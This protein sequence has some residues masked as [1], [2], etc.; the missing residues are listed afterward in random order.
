MLF[1][2]Q[3]LED[4]TVPDGEHVAPGAQLLKIWRMRNNGA[5]DW[6]AGVQLVHRSGDRFGTPADGVAATIQ[7]SVPRG[8]DVDVVAELRMPEA[9]SP[10]VGASH[11]KGH[12]QLRLPGARDSYFGHSVWI[13]VWVDPAITAP[14]REPAVHPLLG[15]P[16]QA[17]AC[18]SPARS[19][20]FAAPTPSHTQRQQQQQQEQLNQLQREYERQQREQQEQLQRDQERQRLEQERQSREQEAQLQREHERQR[21]ERQT[22]QQQEQ[23]RLQQLQREQHTQQWLDQQRQQQEQHHQHHQ[24]QHRQHP[25][26]QEEAAAVSR[27]LADLEQSVSTLVGQLTGISRPH[28]TPFGSLPDRALTRDSCRVDARELQPAVPAR[29]ST[30][31]TAAAATTGTAISFGADGAVATPEPRDH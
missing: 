22:Q 11:C 27:R 3:F 10:L 31:T 19:P 12:F 13:E 8:A 1:S 5:R 16:L 17:E 4:V 25:Q 21:L 20:L 26:A 23:Q 14:A 29:T 15:Q 24:P 7:E 30:T 18:A 9:P 6:P 28:T 2:S